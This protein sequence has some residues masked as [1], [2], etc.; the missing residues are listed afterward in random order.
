[1]PFVGSYNG[2]MKVLKTIETGSCAGRCR[3]IWTRNFRAALKSASNPL[4]LTPEQRV[5]LT[6]KLDSLKGKKTGAIE[7]TNAKYATRPS[8][9][10]PANKHCGEVKKG[11]DG[12][13]YKSVANKNG[14]CAWR[15][16]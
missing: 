4:G 11:N 15:R 14:V 7:R 5:S 1:M 6:A 12:N 16:A 13:M 2:A 3:S 10:F 8:P 9:P